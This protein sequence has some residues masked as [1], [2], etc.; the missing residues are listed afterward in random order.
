MASQEH[1][2]MAPKTGVLEWKVID[3]LR[4]TG[5]ADREGPVKKKEKLVQ[6][7]TSIWMSGSSSI[8]KAMQM[9]LM[10]IFLHSGSNCCLIPSSIW[11]LG[12]RK[13]RTK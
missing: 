10:V 2:G 6:M 13:G 7:R 9:F 12:E 1:G 5:W 4:K 3:S 8:F 11:C